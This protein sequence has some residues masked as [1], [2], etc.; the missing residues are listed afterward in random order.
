[1]RNSIAATL[2]FIFLFVNIVFAQTSLK[3]EIDKT[4]ITT[5]ETVT[6]KLTIISPERQIPNPQLPKFTGFKVISQAKSSHISLGGSENKTVITYQ[7]ILVPIDIGKFKLQ[8]ATV[9]IKNEVY[10]T[11]G[12]EIEV[13]PGKTKP[14]TQPKERIL[15]PEGLP[16]ETEKPQITL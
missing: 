6:Y 10:S 14:Q 8:P 13:K 2:I 9:K 16:P 1:M 3:A 11:D 15:P 7:F 12:F 5:D 4:Q